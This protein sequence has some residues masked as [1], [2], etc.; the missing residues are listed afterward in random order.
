MVESCTYT[1]INEFNSHHADN[2]RMPH[3]NMEID[4]NNKT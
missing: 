2:L 1:L 3:T 4:N